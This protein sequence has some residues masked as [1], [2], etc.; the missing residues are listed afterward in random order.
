[1]VLP[2]VRD[3]DPDLDGA[4][5]VTVTGRQVLDLAEARRLA[6][7]GDGRRIREAHGLSLAEVGSA[8]GVSPGAVS[9]WEHG[10]RRPFGKPAVAYARLLRVLAS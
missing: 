7:S 6:S 1:M 10:Q 8:V 9:K 3:E 5:E 4:A 2:G